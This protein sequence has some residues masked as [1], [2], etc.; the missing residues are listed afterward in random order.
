GRHIPLII[1][2]TNAKNFMVCEQNLEI[3]RLSL[4]VI[5]YSILARDGRTVVFSI[6]DKI[7][8]FSH[9][10]SNFLRNDYHQNHVI[11]YFTT[12]FN[13]SKYFD[14]IMD[15]IVSEQ[16]EGFNYYM[17]LDNV[18]KL[19]LSRID[20][21]KVIQRELVKEADLYLKNKPV[22]YIGAGPSLN[23]NLD[24]ILKNK[25][26]FIIVS[27]GASCKRLLSKGIIP[28]IVGTVDPQYKVLNEIHFSDEIIE[29]LKNTI[30]LASMN[31]DQRI[32]DKFNQNNLFLYEV[33]FTINHKSK[34]ENGYSIGEILGTILINL[35]VNNIYLI[36]IDLA[37]NQETGETHISGYETSNTFNLKN[38]KSSI[39]KDAFSTRQDLVK[40]KG[41]F[42][43]EVYTSRLFNTSLNTF[44]L[45]CETLKDESQ[46]IYNLSKNGAYIDSTEPLDIDTFDVEKFDSIEESE[47]SSEI[48]ND[49]IYLSKNYLT[50]EVIKEL[51]IERDYLFD[52]KMNFLE[53]NKEYASLDEFTNDYLILEKKL[54]VPEI[55]TTFTTSIFSF[56]LRAVMPYIYYCLNDKALKKENEKLNKISKELKKQLLE[57]SN[58]YLGYLDLVLKK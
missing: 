53:K 42:I 22:L 24:W 2:K 11:K 48:K 50:N 7:Y 54:L 27:M 49:F 23:E 57:I 5:D 39:E 10:G 41:N 3:F 16:T 26:K 52:I 33:I 1:K 4:F 17:M 12:D 31:T 43:D 14:Q 44:S 32:L 29:K 46:K 45:S 13:V 35:G 37:I 38:I 47:K 25:D 58:K 51:Q 55:K 40:V 20:K 8:E 56:Y 28:D 18:A 6:M 30:I 34:V 9:K 15:A 21:Y 19:A 36:G